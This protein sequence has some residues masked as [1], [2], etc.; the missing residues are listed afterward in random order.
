MMTGGFL[1]T[2]K[3][4]RYNEDTDG[5]AIDHDGGVPL[6]RVTCNKK[7]RKLTSTGFMTET[8]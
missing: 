7:K 3:S 5:E 6:I 8:H 4:S 2:K 1:H